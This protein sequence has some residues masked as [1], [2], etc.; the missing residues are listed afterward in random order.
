M[1][2][3]RV[4]ILQQSQDAKGYTYDPQSGELV[5]TDIPEEMKTQALAYALWGSYAYK[6]KLHKMDEKESD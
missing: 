3:D 6:Q 2:G 1:R 5:P 4:A